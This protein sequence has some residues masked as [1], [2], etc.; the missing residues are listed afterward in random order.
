MLGVSQGLGFSAGVLVKNIIEV[1][2]GV[3]SN[4]IIFAE[5]LSRRD[6][7]I[8]SSAIETE[9]RHFNPLLAPKTLKKSPYLRFF[10][11][12]VLTKLECFRILRDFE[13]VT[14]LDT[15]IL[16]RKSLA[17]LT[18]KGG[19]GAKF[20]MGSSL[21]EQFLGNI[22]SGLD[23]EA[24]AMFTGTFSLSKNLKTAEAIYD[25]AY[26]YLEQFSH[27]LYLPDQ[28]IITAAFLENGIP[29]DPI[30]IQLFAPHP[31]NFQEE[32]LIIHAYGRRKFWS[33][34]HNEAWERNYRL[35][36]S[37]GGTSYKKPGLEKTIKEVHLKSTIRLHKLGIKFS[38]FWGNHL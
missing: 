18:A 32:A 29:F 31:S 3:F 17:P 34:L 14:W 20:M 26:R 8:I 19:S 38:E 33:G 15:D 4:L 13:T 36:L 23:G 9:V 11:P 22:P 5:D 1:S 25:S 6:K 12:Y 35:W 2:E 10:T 7:E 24:R 28:A 27:L 37:D 21:Q 16:V 30:D